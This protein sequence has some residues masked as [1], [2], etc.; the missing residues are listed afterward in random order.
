MLYNS[1][2]TPELCDDQNI[3][4]YL[5]II[6]AKL[7]SFD[8]TFNLSVD[9]YNTIYEL[10]FSDSTSDSAKTTIIR[11]I[12]NVFREPRLKSL[13]LMKDRGAFLSESVLKILQNFTNSPQ[14]F[15]SI[16]EL[17]QSIC[18][19]V[20]NRQIWRTANFIGLSIQ[21]FSQII[22]DSDSDLIKAMFYSF[23][24]FFKVNYNT[25]A[26]TESLQQQLL[27]ISQIH[28]NSANP[29]SVQQVM[30]F[31]RKTAKYE[32]VLPSLVVVRIKETLI[33]KFGSDFITPVINNLDG[34]SDNDQ[35]IEFM[36]NEDI[37]ISTEAFEILNNFSNLIPD[38][39]Y[40]Q[41]DYFN[42]CLESDDWRI[43]CKGLLGIMAAFT[44]RKPEIREIFE[45]LMAPNS[46]GQ[47]ILLQ[48]MNSD[49]IR[50]R[51]ITTKL[52]KFAIKNI[53]ST[54]FLEPDSDGLVSIIKQLI[55]GGIQQED[56]DFLLSS[57]SL[58][59]S[60]A[61]IFSRRIAAFLNKTSDIFG[62]VSDLIINNF[63]KY[64]DDINMINAL[65]GSYE[66]LVISLSYELFNVKIEYSLKFLE[67]L[68]STFDESSDTFKA[69][70]IEIIGFLIHKYQIPRDFAIQLWDYMYSLF[71]FTPEGES[72]S[73]NDVA[74]SSL[75]V[76]ELLLE[77]N[78]D[79]I[80]DRA[81][82][83]PLKILEEIPHDISA[84][85]Y[86]YCFFFLESYFKLP[87]LNL[88]DYYNVF[89]ENLLDIASNC[90][91]Q[92]V[93]PYIFR[94]IAAL[95]L[96][97][98]LSALNY[99]DQL[100]SIP[101]KF[102]EIEFDTNESTQVKN[103]REIMAQLLSLNF[104]LAKMLS[105]TD[106]ITLLEQNATQ[107]IIFYPTVAIPMDSM[108][109]NLANAILLFIDN[110]AT[111]DKQKLSHNFR[112]NFNKKEIK[113]TLEW[114]NKNYPN[115]RTLCTVVERTKTTIE[116]M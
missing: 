65:K 12:S 86:E 26:E 64:H 102:S 101:Q 34:L 74:S 67:V 9:Y 54:Y 48:F 79:E 106:N 24:S 104:S 110:M 22:P 100:I 51:S 73:M 62:Q 92:P 25:I 63:L 5:S 93:L 23:S 109:Y 68:Q 31:Y 97:S 44:T 6:I 17:I 21:Y 1:I 96:V 49:I 112:S 37:S 18:S 30:R 113:E 66:D 94:A 89:M 46:S 14:F 27:E 115:D 81:G 78:Y 75:F 56:P 28:I 7:I 87:N 16:F 55:V 41:V 88:G 77:L 111:L 71:T 40:E 70:L 103:M 38:L 90:Y 42:E 114:I 107:R 82:D 76:M 50:V 84:N 80:R 35:N 72:W 4:S 95:V 91:D 36:S 2:L 57:L 59:K 98:M 83:L 45:N 53:G 43:I 3:S 11:T 99:Y 32:L 105:V 85:N 20:K 10:L 108:N 58:M 39:V 61:K 19:R 60:F 116:N 33:S 69:S 52:L 47:N 8:I 15:L 29:I 13:L